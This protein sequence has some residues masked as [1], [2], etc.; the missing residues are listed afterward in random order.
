M[1]GPEQPGSS[2][3]AAP[4]ST[5]AR[6]TNL[7]LVRGIAVLTQT[8]IGIVVLRHLL[9]GVDLTRSMILL[10][11]VVVWIAQLLWS[12]AWLRTFRYGPAEWAWRCATYR[13][14]QP[15]RRETAA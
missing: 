13:R 15:I 4:V 5:G 1:F 2:A 14:W 3:P 6:I 10:L 8:I 9:D 12:P 11:I 7:D